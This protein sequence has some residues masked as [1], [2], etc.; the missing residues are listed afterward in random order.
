MKSGK[1]IAFISFQDGQ[2]LIIQGEA[3]LGT[4]RFR[5]DSASASRVFAVK[6]AADAKK[7]EVNELR[8]REQVREE[9]GLIP[10]RNTTFQLE[11]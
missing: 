2:T 4:L 7:K 3:E 11:Q 5:S 9:Q 10:H 6:A 8:C 1:I